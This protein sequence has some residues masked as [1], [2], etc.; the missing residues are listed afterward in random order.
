[1]YEKIMKK[2]RYFITIV[3]VVFSS[4]FV[5]YRSAYALEDSSNKNTA[6]NESSEGSQNENTVGD[7]SSE[8]SQNENTAVGES[9]EDLSNENTTGSESSEGSQNEN[10]AGD[11]SSEGFQNENTAGDESSEG[12]QNENTARDELSDASQNENTAEGESRDAFQNENTAGDESSEGF[13]NE[14]KAGDELSDASQNENTVEDDFDIYKA[15]L[16]DDFDFNQFLDKVLPNKTL[17]EQIIYLEGIVGGRNLDKLIDILIENDKIESIGSILKVYS[18]YLFTIREAQKNTAED[19]IYNAVL[20][21][22]FD[23]NQ[24]LDKVLQNKTLDEQIIYFNAI[25]KFK[26][27]QTLKSNN[28]K[29]DQFDQFVTAYNDFKYN[30]TIREIYENTAEDDLYKDLYQAAHQDDFDFNQFLDKVLKDKTLDEQIKYFNAI[31]WERM[32]ILLQGPQGNKK[33]D[34]YKA[35]SEDFENNLYSRELHE[36]IR[37][38]YENTAEDDLYKDF[39]QAVFQIDFNDKYSVYNDLYRSLDKVLQNKTLDEKVIY[40]KN[41]DKLD[42]IFKNRKIRY[43][44]YGVSEPGYGEPLERIW[45]DTKQDYIFD[46]LYRDEYLEQMEKDRLQYAD[47]NVYGDVDPY[48]WDFYGSFLADFALTEKRIEGERLLYE[49]LTVDDAKRR[50][51]VEYSWY[52]FFDEHSNPSMAEAIRRSVS[53]VE[54]LYSGTKI[55]PISLYGK[56]FVSKEMNGWSN[57]PEDM[58]YVI[59]TTDGKI[60]LN[61]QLLKNPNMIDDGGVK[62]EPSEGSSNENTSGGE[63]SEGSFNETRSGGET[64]EGSSNENT[65]EGETSEGSSNENTSG[66]EPSEDSLNE[67]IAGDEPSEDPSNEKTAGDKLSEDLSNEKTVGDKSS[68]DPTNE[69][70]VGD[71]TGEDPSNE[72]PIGDETG[73][74]PTN[75]NPV[76]D[77]TGEDPSNE[78][79]AGGEPSEGSSNETTTDDETSEDPSNENPAGGEPSEGS[80]NETTTDD[81]TSEDP[82]NEN[83]AGGEPSEGSSNETTTDDETSENP[84]NEKTAGDEPSEDLSNDTIPRIRFEDEH[85]GRRRFEKNDDFVTVEDEDQ[86]VSSYLEFSVSG[87]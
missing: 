86:H 62:G 37:E 54:A 82:S 11:E 22:D 85:S 8:G 55:T 44:K 64:K 73:E 43:D 14:N 84:S 65:S 56:P 16:Q 32:Y 67:K 75:E 12:F 79:P 1:M 49:N 21:D 69:N 27:L 78:N 39:Y 31:S 46:L 7:E 50:W 51:L 58:F 66:G 15:V 13:Q 42:D 41:I 19:N 72:N 35:A 59:V 23:F 83:P 87:K 57:D 6:G 25:D 81:E 34:Q 29:Y 4:T 33:Y 71:E 60:Y 38:L 30:L 76:G 10:T 28:A 52:E 68:E 53:S 45:D 48:D 63:T 36:N 77:E 3:F 9:S 2:F 20:Q 17:G 26:V 70:P 5:S 74:D 47:H 61:G 18:E 24:F 40:L 80:S